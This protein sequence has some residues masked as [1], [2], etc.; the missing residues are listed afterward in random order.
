MSRR[1]K[2]VT[3]AYGGSRCHNCVRSRILRS[4]LM[5]EQKVLKQILKEKKRERVKQAIEKRKAAAKAER[6]AATKT[7]RPAKSAA[8]A[9]K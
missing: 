9:K 3:R 7:D 4:F 5:E 6:Q 1:E 2:T 8:K